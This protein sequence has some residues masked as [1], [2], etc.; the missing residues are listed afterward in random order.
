MIHCD[1]NIEYFTTTTQ[2]LACHW[3]LCLFW[4]EH[5]S[6]TYNLTYSKEIILRDVGWGKRN[7]MSTSYL[8]LA[9]D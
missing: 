8:E 7:R 2:K 3:Y 1:M 6:F 9:Q 4:T 5:V